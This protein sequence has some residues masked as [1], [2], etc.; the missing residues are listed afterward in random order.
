MPITGPSPAAAQIRAA[1]AST[2]VFPDPAGALMTDTSWASV[3][4]DHAAAVWSA[5][6]P[7]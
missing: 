3:S 4:T 5:R 2:R 7:D 6:S 1:S